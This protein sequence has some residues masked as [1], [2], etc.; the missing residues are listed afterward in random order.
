[1][2]MVPFSEFCFAKIWLGIQ[3]SK[4]TLVWCT[5]VS[6]WQL[7][8]LAYSWGKIAKISNCPHEH[9]KFGHKLLVWYLVKFTIL[10][11]I[12]MFSKT[13][14]NWQKLI[15]KLLLEFEYLFKALWAA[16]ILFSD[17]WKLTCQCESST[18]RICKLFKIPTAQ[19]PLELEIIFLAWWKADYM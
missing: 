13:F 9:T 16:I 4:N 17:W 11:K 10:S 3:D 7:A 2:S 19:Q 5:K 12:Q 14:S 6:G 15:N 18:H 1:M 8:C